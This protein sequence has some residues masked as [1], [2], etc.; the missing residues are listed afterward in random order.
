[1]QGTPCPDLVEI[2]L[3]VYEHDEVTYGSR[4]E[5][6]C[7]NT[8]GYHGCKPVEQP[9]A[10]KPTPS[11]HDDVLVE[12]VAKLLGGEGIG[13]RQGERVVRLVL[14]EAARLAEGD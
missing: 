4:P 8:C 10:P 1:M 9:E 12:A 3:H 7:E 14:Q 5:T 13:Q 11:E 2:C 6:C